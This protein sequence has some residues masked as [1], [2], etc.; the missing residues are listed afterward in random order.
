MK[1]IYLV[2]RYKEFPKRRG[3][4]RKLG[5]FRNRKQAEE[6]AISLNEQYKTRY[7]VEDVEDIGQKEKMSVRT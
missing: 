6:Y 5:T 3:T 4:D 1:K 2:K 7:Y